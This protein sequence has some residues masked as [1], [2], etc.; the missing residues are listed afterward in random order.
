MD[1]NANANVG[2]EGGAPAANAGMGA[3]TGGGG[4][5]GQPPS[6]GS[7]DSA[8]ASSP[9]NAPVS[10]GGGFSGGL[11]GFTSSGGSG[12]GGGGSST[13]TTPE[14][15]PKP[16]PKKPTSQ[17]EEPTAPAKSSEIPKSPANNNLVSTE[18]LAEVK[19]QIDELN[20]AKEE[21]EQQQQQQHL[22]KIQTALEEIEATVNQRVE[23][24]ISQLAADSSESE[25]LKQKQ[26]LTEEAHNTV[27]DFKVEMIGQIENRH[28]QI[29]KKLAQEAITK[30]IQ[31]Q[32]LTADYHYDEKALES[33][34]TSQAVAQH[35][36][37][38]V[39]QIEQQKL[40][41]VSLGLK[42]KSEPQ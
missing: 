22:E 14:P 9:N 38:T 6:G 39:K 19:K 35:V 36:Q 5:G 12:G 1:A 26:K 21:F 13:S 25:A 30:Y 18:E 24:A 34:T 3:N 10:F 33:L 23:A 16:T 17:P 29:A 20:Q 7:G 32:G 4:G 41:K 42:P 2:D 11:G 27:I 28:I 31:Q 15:K 8:P 37:E 40:Q